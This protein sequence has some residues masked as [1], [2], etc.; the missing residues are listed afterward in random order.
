MA[1]VMAAVRI[2]VAV[3]RAAVGRVRASR[4]GANRR[5][6]DRLFNHDW[7]AVGGRVAVVVARRAIV[8]A[9]VVAAM[10]V[11][12]MAATARLR[13]ARLSTARLGKRTCRNG[14]HQTENN[15]RRGTLGKT[16]HG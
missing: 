4:V 11:A 8:V 3:V 13:A 16:F 1:R 14:K 10:I 6:A 2:R 5:L 7:F 12:T 15:D 9:V